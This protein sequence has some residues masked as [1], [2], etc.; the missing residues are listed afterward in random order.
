MSRRSSLVLGAV[1]AALM[2]TSVAKASD[3]YPDVIAQTLQA[4]VTPSCTICHASTAGGSGTVVKP[5]G[6][7]LQQRG[8]VSND[9]NSLKT[10]LTA[11]TGERHDTDGDGIT[12]GD[13]LKNGTD[14][15]PS[16]TSNVA[17]A[18]YGCGRIAPRADQS[19]L[20]G[21][22]ALAVGTTLMALGRRRRR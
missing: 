11:M 1:A 14:P 10:A 3:E 6:V 20:A 19:G 4:K 13:E 17:E 15:N 5:F 21:W 2:C 8:L 16:A 22:A 7:Y 9:A 12:D 18:A